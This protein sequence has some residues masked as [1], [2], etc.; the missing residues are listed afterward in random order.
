MG[1]RLAVPVWVMKPSWLAY[2]NLVFEILLRNHM[3]QK[4]KLI[5]NGP[6]YL[7]KKLKLL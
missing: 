6:L 5:G 1:L 2:L 3:P 7:S 4:L